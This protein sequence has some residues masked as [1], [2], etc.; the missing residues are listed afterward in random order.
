M[1]TVA[2][3]KEKGCLSRINF[4]PTK[5]KKRKEEHIINH[6]DHLLIHELL[7]KPLDTFCRAIENIEE[8][9]HQPYQA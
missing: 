3:K 8:Y 4:S 9:I 1:N 5:K 7:D 6:Q 2:C